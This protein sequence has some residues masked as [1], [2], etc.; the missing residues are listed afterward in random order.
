MDKDWRAK[1]ALLERIYPDEYGRSAERPAAL[2]EAEKPLGVSVFL[3]TS[4]GLQELMDF[5][6]LKQVSAAKED[7]S[8]ADPGGHDDSLV[9]HRVEDGTEE[10]LT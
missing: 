9:D 10:S 8:V 7:D 3:N 1:L 6:V 5:P 4:K 2:P